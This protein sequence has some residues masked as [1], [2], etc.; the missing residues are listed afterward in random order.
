MREAIKDFIQYCESYFGLVSVTISWLTI[1]PSLEFNFP[2]AVGE[3]APESISTFGQN[4]PLLERR[5]ANPVWWCETYEL[6][7]ELELKPINW[8]IVANFLQKG[9]KLKITP[10]EESIL[11]Q[12]PLKPNLRLAKEPKAKAGAIESRHRGNRAPS[13]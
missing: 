8:D 4:K 13:I 7:R 1:R 5:L 11:R 10:E 6:L 3:D 9:P 2:F 12:L